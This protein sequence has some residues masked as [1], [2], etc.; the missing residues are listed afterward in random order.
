[1]EILAAILITVIAAATPLLFAAVGELVV[2]KSGVLNLG[3]EGMMVLG[4]VGAFATSLTTGSA[5]LGILAGAAA[6]AVMA[7]VFAVLTLT[8][9]ANQVASGLA[10]TIFGIGASALIGRGFVG[11]P[12]ERLP[13]LDLPGPATWPSWGLCC[14]AMTSWSIF[15]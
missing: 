10:L 6:G 14:L 11:M 3:V 2:E 7:L 12:L 1:M 13:G 8:L 9:L 4:A 15:P 5:T